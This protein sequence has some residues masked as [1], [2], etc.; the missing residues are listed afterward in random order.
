MALAKE[1]RIVVDVWNF[2]YL[3]KNYTSFENIVLFIVE[4]NFRQT[5]FAH[6]TKLS[7][8]I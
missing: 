8:S 6:F 5:L 4:N 1:F 7:C 2:V 3:V